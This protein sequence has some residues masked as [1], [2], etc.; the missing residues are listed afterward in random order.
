MLDFGIDNMDT[1]F[2]KCARDYDRHS[3]EDLGM[4]EFYDEIEKQ[5]NICGKPENILV[6]GCGTGLEIERIKYAANVTAIDIS[7]GMLAELNKK[8]L[9]LGVK[10]N[11]V[12]G[13]YFDVSFTENN[14]DL[15]L[16]AYSLHHF[17]AQKKAQLYIKIYNCLKAGGY[18]INGDIV[19][20]DK[21]TETY[22]MD[23]AEEIYEEQQLPF[24][25]L[26]ID[27]PMAPDTELAL[28]SDAGFRSISVERRWD[29]SALIKALK[30]G[31]CD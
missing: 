27:V 22:F 1:H 10:L 12:C 16:S 31:S 26:H 17:N 13:S 3:Y 28:L 15:V 23:Q 5:I 21:N 18:F 9:C 29:K 24:G 8:E 14:Y 7:S 20:K 4:G 2:N 30:S 25:S 19:C 11:T 6:L